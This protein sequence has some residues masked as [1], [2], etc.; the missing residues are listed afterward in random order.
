MKLLGDL[1][2]L[3]LKDREILNFTKI[4]PTAHNVSHTCMARKDDMVLART[5]SEIETM[6]EQAK[7]IIQRASLRAAQNYEAAVEEGDLKASGKVLDLCGAFSKQSDVNVN[8]SFGTWLKQAQNRDEVM[9]AINVTP[10]AP[11][12]PE[13]L[14]I[15]PEGAPI[16]EMPEGCDRLADISLENNTHE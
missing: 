10:D 3:G 1:A 7:G 13:P 6:V 5:N 11:S 9:S 4:K 15:I 8:V 16:D 14:E 12:L 2:S